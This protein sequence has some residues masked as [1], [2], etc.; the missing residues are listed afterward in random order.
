MTGRRSALA[1]ALNDALGLDLASFEEAKQFVL[2]PDGSA[3]LDA[4]LDTSP[5]DADDGDRA[6]A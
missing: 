5:D 1:D 2:S 6:E 4:W 3:A